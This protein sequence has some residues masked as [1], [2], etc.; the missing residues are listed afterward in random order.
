M[1]RE[2]GLIELVLLSIITFGIYFLFWIHQL[3]RDVN[4]ICEGD[5]SRTSDLPR[6]LVFSIISLG[7]Y[8]YVWL[9]MLGNRL[10][11]NAPRYGRLF[12]ES[13]SIIVLWDLI[14]SFIVIGP[15]VA[16]YIVIKNTNAL[17]DAYNRTCRGCGY[18]S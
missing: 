11:D 13:G 9:Y 8:N 18:S 1:I 14:G 12:R 5:G 3:A 4:L 7:I 2:R 10:Y 16:W 17:A 6:Y 15:L